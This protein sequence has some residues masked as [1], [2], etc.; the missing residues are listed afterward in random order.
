VSADASEAAL[1][2]AFRE[3]VRGFRVG[4]DA[5]A[6]RAFVRVVDL[7]VARLSRADGALLAEQ[8]APA[9][10]RAMAAQAREDTLELA[11]VLEHEILPRLTASA[12]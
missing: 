8:V 9:L 7:L 11:D 2:G 5:E 12:S 4:S 6:H 3:A 1:L 10:E